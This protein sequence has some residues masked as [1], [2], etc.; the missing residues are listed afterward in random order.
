MTGISVA[1]GG[2]RKGPQPAL[3]SIPRFAR[4][5]WEVW[6]QSGPDYVSTLLIGFGRLSGSSPGRGGG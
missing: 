4:I 5:Q 6:T 2:Q 3:D 1:T